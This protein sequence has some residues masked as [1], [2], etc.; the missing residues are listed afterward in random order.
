MRCEAPWARKTPWYM[1]ALFDQSGA[2]IALGVC[3]ELLG[4]STEA[5]N[6]RGRAK[7]WKVSRA[8]LE[9]SGVR[10]ELESVRPRAEGLEARMQETASQKETI[11]SPCGAAGG[12]PQELPPNTQDDP[13]SWD[14]ASQRCLPPDAG[15][16]EQI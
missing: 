9:E 1:S 8:A 7:G 13:V 5:I 10:T 15:Y 16:Y 12:G 6:R 11:P 4:T 3:G 14:G 2:R